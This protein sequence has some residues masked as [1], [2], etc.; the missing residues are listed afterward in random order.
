[1]QQLRDRFRGLWS[2]THRVF[3]V[4]S[5][6]SNEILVLWEHSSLR[7]PSETV[8]RVFKSDIKRRVAAQLAKVSET[9]YVFCLEHFLRQSARN[10]SLNQNPSTSRA[11][12]GIWTRDHYLT[13]VTPHRA[14][15]PRHILFCWSKLESLSFRSWIF[16]FDP[17]PSW[18]LS[19]LST[20][21]EIPC[22]V[23]KVF[24]AAKSSIL[25]YVNC[26]FLESLSMWE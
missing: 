4:I 19:A 18:P 21:R 10:S 22:W 14:R 1:M 23:I 3:E 8:M 9:L 13:K 20:D 16:A 5:C 26:G 2:V 11:S 24:R 25:Q 6:H 17:W 7:G 15:L 12:G